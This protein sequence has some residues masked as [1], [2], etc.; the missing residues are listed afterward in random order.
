MTTPEP[1]PTDRPLSAAAFS[2]AQLAEEREEQRKAEGPKTPSDPA[3]VP[4][5]SV[6][7]PNL[8]RSDEP[9]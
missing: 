7:E 4:D 9:D 5:P 3:A 2:E 6:Q 8:V 1:T